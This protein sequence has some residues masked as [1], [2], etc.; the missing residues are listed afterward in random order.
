MTDWLWA[1]ALSAPLW[2]ASF[3][4]HL[5]YCQ[6]IQSTNGSSHNHSGWGGAV[7]PWLNWLKTNRLNLNTLWDSSKITGT[8]RTKRDGC[9]FCLADPSGFPFWTKCKYVCLAWQN[10]QKTM[11]TRRPRNRGGK[12]PSAH[13][14]FSSQWDD[15]GDT[16]PSG[17]LGW[18]NA[19]QQL[20]VSSANREEIAKML[21]GGLNQ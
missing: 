14:L 5:L 11:R 12:Y 7:F 21:V 6:S 19:W 18:W 9:W 10:I 17:L 4:R 8:E 13:V 2:W 16:E 3:C 15:P 20:S 1:E